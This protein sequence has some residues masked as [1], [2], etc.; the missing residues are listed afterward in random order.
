MFKI[1][2]FARVEMIQPFSRNEG[3]EAVRGRDLC[4]PHCQDAEKAESA[5]PWFTPKHHWGSIAFPTRNSGCCSPALAR[6][7]FRAVPCTSQPSQRPHLLHGLEQR[8]PVVLERHDELQ[9]RAPRLHGCGGEGT[10]HRSPLPTPLQAARLPP[11]LPPPP[12]WAPGHGQGPLLPGSLGFPTRML[13]HAL[14]AFRFCGRTVPLLPMKKLGSR[15]ARRDPA[16]TATS[17]RSLFQVHR[18]PR[19]S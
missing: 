16:S 9:L 7:P 8:L 2:S 12:T 18:T 10:G 17:P 1:L 4:C 3:G 14:P 5:H 19:T 6:T 11:H 13:T 15:M